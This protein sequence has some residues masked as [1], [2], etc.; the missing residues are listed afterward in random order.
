MM[1]HR[2][3]FGIARLFA[4]CNFAFAPPL[5]RSPESPKTS[6]RR[7]Y[8][9]QKKFCSN[10]T[11]GQLLQQ[12]NTT[13]LKL[14][15]SSRYLWLAEQLEADSLSETDDAEFMALVKKDEK[16]RNKRLQLLIKLSH[17]RNVSLPHLM[18]TLG[19]VVPQNG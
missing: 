13:A 9:A 12:I 7:G 1:K 4:F 17:L 5:P 16:L 2:L 6:V 10:Q 3:P 14:Q 8:P 19:L 15:E 11:E 18:K